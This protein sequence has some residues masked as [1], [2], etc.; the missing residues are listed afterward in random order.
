MA[1]L[2]AFATATTG[3]AVARRAQAEGLR[4]VSAEM[5]KPQISQMRSC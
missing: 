4:Y 3:L 5:A 2:A 1:G